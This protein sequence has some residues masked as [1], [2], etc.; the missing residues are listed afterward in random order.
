MLFKL[1]ILFANSA[2]NFA[3]PKLLKVYSQKKFLNF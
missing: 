1:F 3:H 2:I